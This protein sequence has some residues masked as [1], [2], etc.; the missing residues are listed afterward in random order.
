VSSRRS[1]RPKRG[2][3]RLCGQIARPA[4]FLNREQT[5]RERSVLCSPATTDL[6]REARPVP[7]GPTP[8]QTVMRDRREPAIVL[9]H[10]SIRTVAFDDRVRIEAPWRMHAMRLIVILLAMIVAPPAFS[11]PARSHNWYNG[12]RSADGISCCSQRDC[13]PVAYRI[14]PDTGRE[15]INAN[16][17]WYPIEYD[18]VL[19]FSSPDGGSHAC[20]GEAVGRPVFRCII[21]PGMAF[22]TTSN[23]LI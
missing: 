2:Q 16:G 7:A 23:A 8:S 14:N 6:T 12:L 10:S 22:L 5:S 18:K 9:M 1:G 3:E 11:V 21:L 20:W 13:R 4:S 19:P 17:A 15:E